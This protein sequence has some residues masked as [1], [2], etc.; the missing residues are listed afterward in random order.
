MQEKEITI[1]DLAKIVNVS[2]TTVSRALN[3]L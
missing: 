2:P 1:Y 3:G